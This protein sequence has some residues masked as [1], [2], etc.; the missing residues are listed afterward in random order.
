VSAGG[1]PSSYALD[2]GGP[3]VDA[4]LD[5][6]AACRV[7]A[8]AARALDERFEGD[9]VPRTLGRVRSRLADAPRPRS[10][11]TWLLG[12]SLVAAA[13][14]VAL[15]VAPSRRLSEA[16]PYRGRK[17]AAAPP[18]TIFVKRGS[19]V[20]ALGP[21]QKVRAGDALR[22]VARVERSRYLELRG[23]DGAGQERTLFPGGDSAALVT[24]GEALPGGFIVDGAP[25]SETL[26]A[27]I[28]DRAFR[29]GRS[30]D[31]D[32]EV[33]RIDLPKEP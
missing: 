7:R 23:R 10:W 9:V 19:D 2:R 28:A 17:G 24:P 15:M 33:V 29:V 3:D 1:H 5:G 27:L 21:G 16:E 14:A 30:P 26:T 22:F 32:V 8:D 18:L 11:R 6:C 20:W 25:G 4:H 13:A 31:R 12:G